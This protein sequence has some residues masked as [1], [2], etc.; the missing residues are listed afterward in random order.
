M[1]F[2]RSKI[3]S[4]LCSWS[5]S[6][7][8]FHSEW[9][10]KS[11]PGTSLTWSRPTHSLIHF[12]P[13]MRPSCWSQTCPVNSSESLHLTIHL[14]GCFSSRYPHGL[15]SYFLWVSTQKS[16]ILLCASSTPCLPYLL[17]F[18]IIFIT[19]IHCLFSTLLPNISSTRAGILSI[20]FPAESPAS[21]TGA[22]A[23]KVL[24]IYESIISYSLFKDHP[25][26]LFT[27]YPLVYSEFWYAFI[28][29]SNKI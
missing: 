2:L 22:V 24:H 18:T 26:F 25:D 13:V 29:Y 10:W 9:K 7:V 6:G 28:S 5:F 1:I 8:P 4:L 19:I 11:G 15:L 17:F 3:I 12:T 20:V 21:R 16:K 23:W 14:P 27:V